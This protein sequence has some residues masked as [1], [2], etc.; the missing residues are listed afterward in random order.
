MNAVVIKTEEELEIMRQRCKLLAQVFAMLDDVVQEGVTT[1][2]INDRVEDYNVN[3]LKARP[4]SKGQ[5]DYPYALNSSVDQV[6]CH[7]MPNNVK[8]KSGSILNLDITLEH[9]GYRSEER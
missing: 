7:G 8:L 3:T 4:A 1:M 5:Y 6:V 2:E 9:G